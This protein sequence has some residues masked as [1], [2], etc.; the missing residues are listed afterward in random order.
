MLEPDVGLEV[1]EKEKARGCGRGTLSVCHFRWPSITASAT[2]RMVGHEAGLGEGPTVRGLRAHWRS[3]PWGPVHGACALLG[4]SQALWQ[5]H[6][7]QQM[8]S[9]SVCASW[10]FLLN[11]QAFI[12]PTSTRPFSS[13]LP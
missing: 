13:V 12:A 6:R 1:T 4:G 3:L 10:F 8:L 5:L 9:S 11:H 2:P 7:Q